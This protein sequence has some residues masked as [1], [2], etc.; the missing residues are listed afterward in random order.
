MLL[1]F[2]NLGTQPQWQG[3]EDGARSAGGGGDLCAR[4]VMWTIWFSD[5]G[6]VGWWMEDQSE[7]DGTFRSGDTLLSMCW[8]D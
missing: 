3:K 2:G 5:R 6:R 8:C 4:E 7:W 1:I